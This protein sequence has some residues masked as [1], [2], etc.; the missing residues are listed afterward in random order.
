VAIVRTAYLALL[1]LVRSGASYM[2][3][4]ATVARQYA[5]TAT[6]I[7]AVRAIVQSTPGVAA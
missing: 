7:R 4:E 2:H 5:L 1:A 3:A 6:Q